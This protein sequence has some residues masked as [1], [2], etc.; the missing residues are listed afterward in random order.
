LFTNKSGSIFPSSPRIFFSILIYNFNHQSHLKAALKHLRFLTSF[1]LQLRRSAF[2]FQVP[3]YDFGPQRLPASVTDS[4]F[5]EFPFCNVK[6]ITPAR[7]LFRPEVEEVNT[8]CPEEELEV[9]AS[10]FLIKR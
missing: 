7:R 2:W 9:F 1:Y 5:S 4:R 8:C 6:L 10:I 3:F